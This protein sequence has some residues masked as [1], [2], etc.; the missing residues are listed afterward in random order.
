MKGKKHI[1]SIEAL[2]S[3]TMVA[4]KQNQRI[5]QLVVNTLLP[6]HGHNNPEEILALFYCED[7]DFWKNAT[8]ALDIR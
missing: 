6:L 3:A 4:K 8:K 7:K 2:N 1:V 5:G